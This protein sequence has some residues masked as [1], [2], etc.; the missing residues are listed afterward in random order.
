MQ[1]AQL[2][3]SGAQS[4]PRIGPWVFLNGD[5]VP[6]QDA[7]VSVNDRGFLF[8]HAAYEV[9]AV[10]N[11]KLIDFDHHILRLERTLA[12]IEISQPALDFAH[13]H[14]EMIDRNELREGLVYV[15]VTAGDPGPRDYYGPEG[16][17]P[18]VY[19]FATHKTLISEVAQKGLTAIT[20]EDTRW[21]RRDLK[22]TQLLTQT[23]AY[24]AARRAGA[25]TAILH[26]EGIV[27]EAASANLWIVTAD[28]TLV[29]RDLSSALL[30]GITRG[31][32]V[33][34][35][36]SDGLQVEERAFS[37]QEL[38]SAVEAFTSS[39]GVVIA[40]V[41]SVDGAPVGSGSPG[42]V[43]RKVQAAYYQYIGAD[44]SR[45]DWL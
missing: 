17:E 3:T 35:L 39:T 2:G 7:R 12:G 4:K 34:L 42:P 15:Q 14:K 44:L 45:L 25:D 18:T 1:H 6:A 27:T 30:P 24:R 36:G 33:D 8:A 41:L 19:M 23:L 37:L 32:L 9:T 22:T 31:R 16:F 10:F 29:T 21:Q 20:Y 43:T 13:L 38:G 11:G 28:G 26:E 40:P 5:F